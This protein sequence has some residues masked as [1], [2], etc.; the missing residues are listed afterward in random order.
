MFLDFSE[1]DLSDSLRGRRG[2]EAVAFL[3]SATSLSYGL[4]VHFFRTKKEA[5]CTGPMFSPAFKEAVFFRVTQGRRSHFFCGVQSDNV[6]FDTA[7]AAKDKLRTKELLHRKNLPTPIGGLISKGS[8]RLLDELVAAG[9]TRFVV[10]PVAGSMAERTIVNKTAVQVLDYLATVPKEQFLLEQF[11]RGREFRVM[12]VNG[13]A[14]AAYLR[15]PAHV[16]GNG[17]MTVSQLIERK[18]ARR[19]ANP[20]FGD[21]QP[22]PVDTELSL[23]SQRLTKNSVPE[24]GRFVWLTIDM[25]PTGTGDFV[26]CLHELPEAMCN[27]AVEAARAVAAKTVAMDI[28][29]DRTGKPFVLDLNLRPMMAAHCFPTSTNQYNPAVPEAVIGGLFRVNDVQRRKVLSYDFAALKTE[30]LREGR[31]SQGVNAADFATFA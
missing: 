28:V 8:T 22:E 3:V 18:L 26:D 5:S 25:K 16:I 21:R 30:L 17:T 13:K 29:V 4:D 2:H 11:I 20:I 15:V 23:L 19:K 1:P 24:R 6:S 7:H 14:V 12:V 9:V 31:T 10:K 27:V